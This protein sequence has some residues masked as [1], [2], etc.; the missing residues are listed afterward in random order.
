MATLNELVAERQG[1]I[2]DIIDAGGELTPEILE[3]IASSD[4]KI[5][6]KLDGY[7][8]FISQVKSDMLWCDEQQKMYADR[9]KTMSNTID[10]LRERM[11]QAMQE[12]D[13][14]KVKT[15]SH[16][17]S[18]RE[19]QSWKL[20]EGLPHEELKRLENLGYG[21]FEFRPDIKAIKDGEADAPDFI[22]VTARPSI[23][24]R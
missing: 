21:R 18:V 12:I 8:G 16:S 3:R 14:D 2:R 9:K 17:Y 15:A 5:G 20:V 1:I 7:A 23:T 22:E 6:D 4:S 24:I 19:V 13:A 11:I 10:N